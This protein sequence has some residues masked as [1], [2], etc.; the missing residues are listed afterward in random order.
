[1]ERLRYVARSGVGDPAT[2]VAE[3]VD[4][5]THLRPAPSELVALCRNLVERT[6]SCG[7]LWWL[8]ARLLGEPGCL[9]DAWQL[10]DDVVCD[11]TPQR[12]AEHV[13]DDAM[14]LTV[15][16]PALVA[17]GLHR[18]GNVA[19]LAVTAGEFGAGMVRRMDRADVPVE[20]V[21]AEAMLSALRRTDLLLVEADACS[22]ASVV[23]TVGSGLAAVAAAAV[24]VPVWLVAGR[25]RRL[26]AA[27]VDAIGRLATGS[28]TFSTEYV[29]KVV[30]P[31]GVTPTSRDALAAECPLIP[32]LLPG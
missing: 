28:E 30:G 15:G 23:A 18:H 3:T 21:A 4:A 29:S 7:P 1:M 31:Q 19:V 9:D 14:V 20:A 2:I 17:E 16:D 25:G 5:L 24:D 32:E 12:L 6:P 27:Y 26:P 8:G 11:P 13:P 10:A 22:V